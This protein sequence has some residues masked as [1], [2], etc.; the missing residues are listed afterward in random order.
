MTDSYTPYET[1]LEALLERLGSDH[2][3][4][5]EA[6]TYEQRLMENLA[7]SRR[8]G[9]TETRR[10]ARAEIVERLNELAREALGLSYSALY[11]ASDRDQPAAP[12]LGQAAPGTQVT[13]GGGTYVGGD[14][15]MYGGDFVGW[16]QVT[17]EGQR[18]E[19]PPLPQ[20]PAEGAAQALI[21]A[22]LQARRL[23]VVWAEVPFPPQERPPNPPA[24]LV[25]RWQQE[26][27]GLSPF[28]W[29]VPELPPL[30]LLSL[31]PSQRVEAVFRQADVPLNV[32]RTQEDVIDP[33]QHNLIKLGGDLASHTGL[34]LAWAGVRGV[35]NEPDRV[36]LL[37]EARRVAQ[38]GIVLMLARA[39][40]GRFL[41]LWD[42]LIVPYT[43]DA[44]HRFALG[45]ANSPW[46]EGVR[47]L[48]EDL[49]GVLARLTEV[50]VS[51]APVALEAPPPT[52]EAQALHDKLEEPV[53]TESVHLPPKPYHRLVGRTEELQVVLNALRDPT[54]KPIIAIVGLVG[55]L[56]RI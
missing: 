10:A 6:Q 23:L 11:R 7:A 13:T 54:R 48:S 41:Q 53:P 2:A 4:Y 45:P 34:L 9:D 29:P 8:Y 18:P 56:S 22:A 27:Q 24:R 39:S 36:H 42:E 19:L 16:D 20:V 21:A 47:H 46:P 55:H 26:A 30:S 5:A 28:P 43:A 14:A 51:P 33:S 31:D 17:P 35:P 3:R 25:N 52:G 40:E 37:R 15:H 44:G 50:E 1:G 32:L 12:P 49:D 38:D